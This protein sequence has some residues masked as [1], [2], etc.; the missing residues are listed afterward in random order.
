MKTIFQILQIKDKSNNVH[1]HS[2]FQVLTLC[3]PDASYIK[4]WV[5]YVNREK[6]D[7]IL[8]FNKNN[9]GIVDTTDTVINS[10][11]S[12]GSLE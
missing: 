12:Q 9:L 7:C 3:H 10:G 5:A 11:A 6:L 1:D 4:K 8:E 2:Y